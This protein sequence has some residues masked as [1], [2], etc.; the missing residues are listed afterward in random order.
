MHQPASPLSRP[1]A[2]APPLGP[3]HAVPM[4]REPGERS[5]SRAGLQR[6]SV[7]TPNSFAR[8]AAAPADQP[9]REHHYFQHLQ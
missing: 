8:P 1:E 4:H 9:P 7:F 5:A 6:R 2:D 3:A